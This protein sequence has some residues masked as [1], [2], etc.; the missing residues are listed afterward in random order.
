MPVSKTISCVGVQNEPPQ[1]MP[2]WCTDYLELK[3]TL[4]SGSRGA[5]AAP[6]NYLE[7]LEL[8]DLPIISDFIRR[9][10]YYQ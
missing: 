4:A 7:D 3:A 1:D 5:S 2:Q 8:G 10:S 9:L 6:F